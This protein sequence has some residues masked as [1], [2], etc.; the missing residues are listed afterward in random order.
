MLA[1]AGDSVFVDILPL[2]HTDGVIELLKHGVEVYHLRRT[3][4]IAK[5]REELKLSKSTKKDVKVL[6]SIGDKWFRRVSED[7]LIMRRMITA[8]RSLLKS[9]HQLLN[10]SKALSEHERSMLKPAIIVI[11]EQ[12]KQMAEKIAEE[13]GKRCPVYNQLIDE[14]GIA[15]NPPAVEALAEIL[16]LPEWTSWRKTRNYF[17]LWKRDRRTYYHRSKTARQAL[18]RLTISIK[19]YG[20]KAGDLKDVLRRMWLILKTQKAGSPPA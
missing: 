1:K 13:A 6:M 5:K 7:F 17:G 16:V 20:I 18:E 19:G 4:L 9:R 12:M 14:L 3:T 15:G 8:Y 11:E 10:K 2:H